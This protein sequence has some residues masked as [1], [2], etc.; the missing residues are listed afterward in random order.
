MQRSGVEDEAE[1][2]QRNQDEDKVQEMQRCTQEDED[3]GVRWSSQED[4]AE[5]KQWS[6]KEEEPEEMQSR[7]DQDEAEHKQPRADEDMQSPGL[8]HPGQ[9]KKERPKRKDHRNAEEGVTT[10]RT[11]TSG[12]EQAAGAATPPDWSTWGQ[13][14]AKRPGRAHLGRNKEQGQPSPG[15]EHP[16]TGG[17]RTPRTRTTATE[18]KR[19][20]HEGEAVEMQRSGVE[21]QAEERQRNQDE[22]KAQE[23]QRCRQED[24][25]PGMRWS[26]QGD[27]AEEAVERQRGGAR[28]DAQ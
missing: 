6:G 21:D 20:G 4:E 11:G 18:S 5:E 28:G 22:D 19:S 1:E 12:A 23:M 13:V 3:A 2:K 25:D 10:P 24:E 8:N 16:R 14:A 7:G 26:S 27:E 9:N 15:V 17:G